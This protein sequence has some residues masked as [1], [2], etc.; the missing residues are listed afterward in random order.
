[1]G[2]GRCLSGRGLMNGLG[3]GWREWFEAGTKYGLCVRVIVGLGDVGIILVYLVEAVRKLPTM[4]CKF[5]SKPLPVTL[6][7]LNTAPARLILMSSSSRIFIIM[8]MYWCRSND[9][10]FGSKTESSSSR[11]ARVS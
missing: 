8:R 2:G 10:L 1:M 6:T 7:F 9:E 11:P 4:G 3:L 5:K